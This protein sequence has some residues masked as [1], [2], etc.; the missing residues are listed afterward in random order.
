M[1]KLLLTISMVSTLSLFPMTG[2]AAWYAVYVSCSN[3]EQTSTIFVNSDDLGFGDLLSFV[4]AQ[5]A[6]SGYISITGVE[7]V[8]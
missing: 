4:A 3:S 1:K 7:K 2:H 5:S 8:D 6:C